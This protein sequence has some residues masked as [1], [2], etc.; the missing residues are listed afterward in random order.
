MYKKGKTTIYVSIFL[1]LCVLGCAT[2]QYKLPEINSRDIK[3][4]YDRQNAKRKQEFKKIIKQKSKLQHLRDLSWPLEVSAVKFS[5][6]TQIDAGYGFATVSFEDL[7]GLEPY[8]AEAYSEVFDVP[9][10]KSVLVVTGITK[11][12]AAESSGLKIRDKI[13]EVDGKKF[14]NRSEFTKL[15]DKGLYLYFGPYIP[16]RTKDILPI[17]TFTVVRGEKN[18]KIS[19]RPSRVSKYPIKKTTS[20]SIIAF[21]N[22]ESVYITDGMMDFLSD[23]ELQ[24]VIAHELSHNIQKHLEKQQTNSLKASM[25]GAGLD[26]FVKRYTGVSAG[27]KRGFGDSGMFLYKR[28]FERESDYLAMYILANANIPTDGISDIWRKFSE[29]HGNSGLYSKTHPSYPERYLSIIQTNKEIKE[30]IKSGDDLIPNE[31]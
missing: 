21:A 6:K 22:G 11:K 26:G 4:E 15:I 23:K 5:E 28:D 18:I 29:L 8:K 25:I 9:K 2:P 20:K 31:R 24:F 30:K 16:R 3:A 14:K 13:T 7:I 10:T 17:K 12:S 1:A 27:P 19:M